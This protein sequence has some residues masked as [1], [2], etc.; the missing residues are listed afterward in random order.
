MITIILSHQVWG[1]FVLQQ[2]TEN[3]FSKTFM[4]K[5]N[6]KKKRGGI[7]QTD[8]ALWVLPCLFTLDILFYIRKKEMKRVS[9]DLQKQKKKGN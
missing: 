9:S 7:H 4:P 2:R 6:T 1:W 3:Y 8:Y 5:N